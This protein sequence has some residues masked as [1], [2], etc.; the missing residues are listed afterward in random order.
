MLTEVLH[1][2]PYAVAF[3]L[4][5]ALVGGV[6]GSAKVN[7][8]KA[9][10]LLLAFPPVYLLLACLYSDRTLRI[11]RLADYVH[12]Y[13]D[14][15]RYRALV[16]LPQW[17]SDVNGH[18]GLCK[19]LN[20]YGLTALRMSKAYHDERMPAELERADYHVSSNIGRTIS[21]APA[22]R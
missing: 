12:K 11:L 18:I 15:A 2:A 5:V 20:R 19:L 8:D 3:S 6:L 17:N 14:P 21:A 10:P 1:I 16:V 13:L 7:P 4:P 9:S 22:S